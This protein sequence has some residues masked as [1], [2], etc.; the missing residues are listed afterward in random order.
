MVERS[1]R[2]WEIGFRSQVATD[3][4]RKTAS[5]NFTAKRSAT[6]V[7]VTGP[8]RLPLQRVG[9]CRNMCGTLKN[10]HYLMALSAKHRSKFAA[11]HRQW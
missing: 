9:P 4:S 11:L 3:P 6:G 1:P 2:I 8:R 10:A 5:D 7:S